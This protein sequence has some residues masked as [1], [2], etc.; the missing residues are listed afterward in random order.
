MG[1]SIIVVIHKSASQNHRRQW[2]AAAAIRGNY[3]AEGATVSEHCDLG[4][5]EVE[6]GVDEDTETRRT[7]RPGGRPGVSVVSI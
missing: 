7:G 6:G 3:R 5:G 4:E 1:G 2:R